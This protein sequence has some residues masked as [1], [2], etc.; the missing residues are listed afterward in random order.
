V[1]E[2]EKIDDDY[3]DQRIHLSRRPHDVSSAWIVAAFL[4]LGLVLAFGAVSLPVGEV[5]PKTVAAS[6]SNDS[7]ALAEQI[8]MSPERAR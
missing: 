6:G 1:L 7:A 5:A 8:G 2:N 3:S 4:G